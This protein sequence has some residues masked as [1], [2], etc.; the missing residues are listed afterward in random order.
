MIPG[1]ADQVNWENSTSTCAQGD[2]PLYS[3]EAGSVADIQVKDTRIF[4]LYDFLSPDRAAVKFASAHNLRLVLKSSGHNTL[5][6]LSA[7]SSFLIRTTS[8]QNLTFTDSFH[9]GAQDLG[10]AVTVGSGARGQQLYRAGRENGRAVLGGSAGTVCIAGGY[11][12][13]LDI[14]LYPRNLALPLMMCLTFIHCREW[15]TVFHP[16]LFFALR[17]GGSE[18]WGVLVSATFKNYPTFSA[19]STFISLLAEN[20]TAAGALA[21]FTRNIYLTWTSSKHHHRCYHQE[22]D[23]ND[24]LFQL[25]NA[26]G[27]NSDLGSR[28]IPADTYHNSPEKVGQAYKGLLDLGTQEIFGIVVAG[29]KVTENDSAVHPAWRKAKTRRPILEQ[30]TGPSGAS[31]SNEVDIFEPQFK[32]TFYGPNY[33]KLSAIKAKYD[34]HICSL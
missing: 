33:A 9:I 3:L 13:G 31:Y 29:G 18:S 19:T 20:S 7:R 12:L 4:D 2:V 24:L 11:I 32:A 26:A 34:P 8:F 28:L 21:A 27:T 23:I 17:G 5:G 14:L 30:L 10:P 16:D 22:A 25:D 6:G 15:N 1:A